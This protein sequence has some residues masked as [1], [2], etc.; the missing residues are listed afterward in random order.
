LLLIALSSTISELWIGRN[1]SSF[2]MFSTVL[3]IGWLVNLLTVP[4]YFFYL[5]TGDLFWNVISHVVIGA[6]NIGLGFWL[7]VMHGGIAVV[8]AWVSS[9]IIGSCII[10]IS[11]HHKYNLPLSDYLPK[12]DVGI[13]AGSML[14]LL[15]SIL[16]QKF[17][18]G[19]IA[20]AILLCVVII[21]YLANISIPLWRH[22]M[23]RRL[24]FWVH[25]YLLSRG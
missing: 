14:G 5:G 17:A 12:E 13:L 19:H 6:L 1:E 18:Q 24:R 7:G 23:R 25:E 10:L 9:L 2:V 22:P 8:F 20:P 4:A 11:F 15:V 21:I 16:V 3:A